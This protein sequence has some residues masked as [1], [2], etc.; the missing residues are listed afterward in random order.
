VPPVTPVPNG[1]SP[2]A[3]TPIRGVG[4]RS[5]SSYRRDAGGRETGPLERAAATERRPPGRAGWGRHQP[6]EICGDGRSPARYDGEGRT[7]MDKVRR[8]LRP[9]RLPIPPRPHEARRPATAATTDG[10]TAN[11]VDPDGL[12]PSS[13]SLQGRC[14]A[15]YALGLWVRGAGVEPAVPK[16]AWVTAR[17]RPTTAARGEGPLSG[18]AGGKARPSVPFAGDLFSCQGAI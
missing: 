9:V 15:T 2:E 8:L 12:E 10:H 5:D 4:A 18:R 11:E 16:S 13:S 3:R 6:L 17:C 1:A 7:L 14:T